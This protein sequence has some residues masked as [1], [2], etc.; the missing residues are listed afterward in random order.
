MFYNRGRD[1]LDVMA[2]WGTAGG[3]GDT[4]GKSP[5]TVINDEITSALEIINVAAQQ[6]MIFRVNTVHKSG[7]SEQS[8]RKVLG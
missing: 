6:I 3:G 4:K 8:Q 7:C 2:Y 5:E 1:S